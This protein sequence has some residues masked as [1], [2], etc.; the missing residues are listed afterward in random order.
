MRPVCFILSRAVHVWK[1]F[2]NLINGA[3]VWSRLINP[4]TNIEDHRLMYGQ[5]TFIELHQDTIIYM[6]LCI[7]VNKPP[8]VSDR[9]VQHA[10][11]HVYFDK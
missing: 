9:K 4:V 1:E 11:V 10:H 8:V 3:S 7:S 5:H 6:T 2:N